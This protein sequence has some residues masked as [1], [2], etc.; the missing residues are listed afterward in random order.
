MPIYEYKCKL[1]GKKTDAVIINGWREPNTCE[2]GGELFRVPSLPSKAGSYS[3]NPE[4]KPMREISATADPT[5]VEDRSTGKFTTNEDLH[6]NL[7]E[8]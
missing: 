5:Y 2:C 7:G 4:W 8:I 6:P 1:C 3:W